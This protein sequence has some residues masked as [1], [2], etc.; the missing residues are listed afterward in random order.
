MRILLLLCCLLS[1]PLS[2]A[3][4]EKSPSVSPWLYKK[5]TR[6]EKLIGRKSYQSAQ[7]K[8]QA[9]LSDVEQG[10]Y[11]HAVV[12]RSLSSVYALQNQYRKAA[13]TLKKCLALNAL[14]KQQEQQSFLNLGQLYMATEQYRLA[15]KTLQPWL[16][17]HSSPDPETSA[18]LANA[19]TQLKQYRQALPHIKKA[20]ASSKKTPESWYQLNLALYYELDDYK[21]AAKLL[22]RLLQRY[23][24]KKE[25]WNQLGSVYQQL[26]QYH[27]AASIQ[28][29]AYQKGLL[30]SEKEILGL[31]NLFLYVG[32]PYKG[33]KILSKALASGQVSGN[34]KNWEMLANAWMQ[35]K[36]FDNAITALEKA[37]AL[38]A[39]GRLF[40]QLGQIYVEQEQ[41]S[42]AIAAF[43]K[44]LAKGG[45]KRPGEV[46]LL[47][48]ISHY[49][50]NQLAEARS[51]FHKAKGHGK[52][53]K[54]ALQWLDYLNS[55]SD[56]S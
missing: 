47:L 36:E 17:N 12:L 44:A 15:V 51:A 10:G 46:Y 50:L 48:G 7:Q 49:E 9:L 1:L 52:D 20:I 32:S 42:K 37:S 4:K 16:A 39:K 55:N 11:E 31:S 45:L 8:L 5:L 13:E 25:Y 2:A 3:E 34:S 27:K 38:N 18:L 24:D 40:K 56:K 29:L 19:Y 26:K 14:P 35:A 33:A 6:T 53:R 21:S 23:P 43:N 54:A 28:H 22:K 30:T 41:W